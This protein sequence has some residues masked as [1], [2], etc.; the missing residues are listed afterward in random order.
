MKSRVRPITGGGGHK[1]HGLGWAIGFDLSLV[2][3]AAVALPL[4]WRPGDWTRVCAW[5]LKTKT[6]E[7]KDDLAGQ[8]RRSDEIARWAGAVVGECSSLGIRPACFVENYGFNKNNANASRIQESG[9][10]VKLEVWRRW[11]VTLTTV[12]ASQGRKL[13]LGKN[14]SSDPK[15]HVQ[16]ALFNRCKAPKT[17]DE[18]QADAFVVVNFG[19]SEL[20]GMALITAPAAARKIAAFARARRIRA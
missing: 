18:N 7:N 10:A 19:L 11:G 5:L 20:G 2:A 14:P 12:T 9:G 6:P 17:W 3:P 1:L 8:A 16:D 4:D 15:T 13:F